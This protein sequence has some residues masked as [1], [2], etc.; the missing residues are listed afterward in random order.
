[1]TLLSVP[2]LG[3]SALLAGPTL[4]QGL[5]TG[6]APVDYALNRY[7]ITVAIV[8]AALSAVVM[9]IEATSPTLL[10]SR[11]GTEGRDGDPAADDRPSPH[12]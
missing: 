7:I 9:L 1:M 6:A 2:V 5:V 3:A 8:W 11:V 10:P 4:W 12:V